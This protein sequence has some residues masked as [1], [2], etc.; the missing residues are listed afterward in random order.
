[1]DIQELATIKL[2]ELEKDFLVASRGGVNLICPHLPLMI[3]PS[4]IQGQPPQQQPQCCTS[5]CALF[6]VHNIDIEEGQV[7]ASFNNCSSEVSKTEI[8][9]YQEESKLNLLK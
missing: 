4:K 7:Y 5:N 1:M 2:V 6:N 9:H 8:I 3:I